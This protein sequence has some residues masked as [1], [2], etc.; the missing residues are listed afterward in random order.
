MNTPANPT[1]KGP[2][3]TEQQV[4]ALLAEL[5]GSEKVQLVCSAFPNGIPHPQYVGSN[6][7]PPPRG[8]K[9]CWQAYYWHM[10]ATTPPHLREEMLAKAEQAVANTVQAYEEGSWDFVP[11]DHPVVELET[12]A[13]DDI[14][15]AY[16][17]R[18]N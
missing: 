6:T 15:R 13:F 10:V 4:A 16:K 2:T 17:P 12:D 7:P 3:W 8:C 1:K 11:L 14:T 9:N 18:A 5:E